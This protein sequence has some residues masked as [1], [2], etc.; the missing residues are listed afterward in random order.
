LGFATSP[1]RLPGGGHG[2]CSGMSHRGRR[3]REETALTT[4]KG[5]SPLRAFDGFDARCT[6]RGPLDPVGQFCCAQFDPFP[7]S[8]QELGQRQ[9]RRTGETG[10]F[11]RGGKWFNSCV[12]MGETA[13]RYKMTRLR[14][15]A[16]SGATAHPSGRQGSAVQFAPATQVQSPLLHL[17][18]LFHE[19][20]QAAL[21]APSRR[22][23]GGTPRSPPPPGSPP[24]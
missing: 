16:A 9:C 10:R 3:A 17:L 22:S 15:V 20:D 18:L 2:N 19:A 21:H 5:A 12:N 8:A 23:P 24:V 6:L 1:R 13:M 11:R 7:R 4:V 14:T